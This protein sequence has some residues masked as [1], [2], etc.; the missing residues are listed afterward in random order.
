MRTQGQI[1]KTGERRM[2]P[3][4]KTSGEVVRLSDSL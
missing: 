1:Q 2:N 4:T 3:R